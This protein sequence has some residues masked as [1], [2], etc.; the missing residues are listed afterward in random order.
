MLIAEIEIPY[1]RE[2]RQRRKLNFAVSNRNP[3][4]SLTLIGSQ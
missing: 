3:H 2:F 1:Y 4:G